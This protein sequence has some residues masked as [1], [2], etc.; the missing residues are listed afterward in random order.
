MKRIEDFVEIIEV[1]TEGLSCPFFVFCEIV[2]SLQK[3]KHSKAFFIMAPYTKQPR[4]KAL[5]KV[6]SRWS[7]L[8]YNV[9]IKKAWVVIY[10]KTDQFSQTEFLDFYEMLTAFGYSIKTY[11]TL[12]NE[13]N[14][15]TEATKKKMPV[16]N[17]KLRS[18]RG[19][20]KFLREIEEEPLENWKVAPL[21]QESQLAYFYYN[22]ELV[23][24]NKS[25]TSLANEM[26]LAAKDL[27]KPIEDEI[28]LDIFNFCLTG[29]YAIVCE[30]TNKI[31]YNQS[32]NIYLSLKDIK[33]QLEN[34][35]YK[36]ETVQKEFNEFGENSISFL[37]IDW[38][39]EFKDP[40]KRQAELEFYLNQ[41]SNEFL[42]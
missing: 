16:K 9:T 15:K 31:L 14:T 30:N 29:I 39:H 27:T 2:F 7:F 34:K 13:L 3:L 36:N 40:K 18:L 41:A 25:L 37:P 26:N 28:F 21:T 4:K 32:E 11:T 20:I 42:K 33:N 10:G 38:G 1:K 17:R 5:I 6:P 12:K 19:A 22:V 8:K 23:K 35:T 24:K